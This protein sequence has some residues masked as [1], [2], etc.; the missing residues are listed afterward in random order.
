MKQR[1]PLLEGFD[2]LSRAQVGSGLVQRH[3]RPVLQD[4]GLGGNIA[5]QERPHKRVIRALNQPLE[6]IYRLLA[7]QLIDSDREHEQVSQVV[8]Q[9]L[10]DEQLLLTS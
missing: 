8:E 10:R 9:A 6:H 2:E 4:V 1:E 7:L 5:E 3:I